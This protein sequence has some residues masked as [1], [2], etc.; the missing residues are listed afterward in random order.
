MPNVIKYGSVSASSAN[1]PSTDEKAALVGTSGTPS[2]G[3]NFVT[4][5]GAY[6]VTLPRASSSAATGTRFSMPSG[7]EI[8]LEPAADASQSPLGEC[9]YA[10]YHEGVGAPWSAEL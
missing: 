8:V 6:A 5:A 10:R 2:A 4:N 1:I 7:T 3:N 9:V